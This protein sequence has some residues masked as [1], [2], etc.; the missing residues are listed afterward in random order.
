MKVSGRVFPSEEEGISKQQTEGL[1]L[2]SKV[3][4]GKYD[5][6]FYIIK[7]ILLDWTGPN[8][9]SSI[10]IKLRGKVFFLW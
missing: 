10:Q 4:S 7:V 2:S 3:S 5:E 9:I 1:I 8:T 6:C